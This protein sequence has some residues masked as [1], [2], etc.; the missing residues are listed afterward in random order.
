MGIVGKIAGSNDL[1]NLVSIK[2][3]RQNIGELLLGMTNNV[4]LHGHPSWLNKSVRQ[5][6]NEKQNASCVNY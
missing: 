4:A 3:G 2:I 6:S 1:L 5:P